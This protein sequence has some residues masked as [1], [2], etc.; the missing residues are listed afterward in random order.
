MLAQPSEGLGPLPSGGGPNV[1][2]KKEAV[3]RG[4]CVPRQP[5]LTR[6]KFLGVGC[7]TAA[8]LASTMV[9]VSLA[10]PET[11][12]AVPP[13]SPAPFDP[14]GGNLQQRRTSARL[15]RLDAAQLAFTRPLPVIANN[16]EE[17]DYGG[18]RIGNFSKG[19]PHNGLGEVDPAAYNALLLALSTGNNADFEAVPLGGAQPLRNP[20]AGIAFDLEGPDS[21]HLALR[22]AP[23]IDSAEEAGEAAE[24]YWMA[25]ARDVHFS[26]YATNPTSLAAA[27]DLS[28]F[29]D[30][31][32]PKQAGTVTPQTL[33]R[34]NTPGDVNGPY[35]SQ[36]L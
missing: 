24:L 14:S 1:K 32:G 2:I 16:G 17:N 22:P 36:F 20:Q 18:K 33:F 19:L 5:E 15:T 23:R 6:R 13:G 21:H 4:A 10:V 8:T 9:G 26:G 11:A 27:A 3:K 29:S 28:A 7:V 34:G 12:A 35:L 30:F 31:R 25:L